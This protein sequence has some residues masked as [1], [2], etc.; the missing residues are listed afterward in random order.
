MEATVSIA[1]VLDVMYIG[2]YPLRYDLFHFEA[3]RWFKYAGHV[4]D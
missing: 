3:W 1:R 2:P 4:G